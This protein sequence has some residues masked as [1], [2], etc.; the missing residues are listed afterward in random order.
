M[1]R[2]Q[3]EA[4]HRVPDRLSVGD[5]VPPLELRR[6]DGEGTEGTV[7]LNSFVGDRPLV[8]IFGSCT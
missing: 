1:D 4:R 2:A 7:R 5:P 6:L 8:L 3:A